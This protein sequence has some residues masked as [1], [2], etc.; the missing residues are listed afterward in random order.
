MP[1][2]LWL[3]FLVFVLLEF[4]G[5]IIGPEIDQYLGIQ[6]KGGAVA[7]SFHILY[8][9]IWGGATVLLIYLFVK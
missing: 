7:I 3:C 9:Q 2:K 8:Y 4:I 1:Q 5:G 6:I